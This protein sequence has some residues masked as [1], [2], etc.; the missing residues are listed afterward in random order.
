MHGQDTADTVRQIEDK[1]EIT[2]WEV[3]RVGIDVGGSTKAPP[4][5]TESAAAE[6]LCCWQAMALHAR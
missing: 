6:P 2:A 1:P 4:T 5:H 3:D